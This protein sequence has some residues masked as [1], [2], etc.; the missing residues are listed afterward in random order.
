MFEV[1]SRKVVVGFF[2]SF[3]KVHGH[4]HFVLT[5]RRAGAAQASLPL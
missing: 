4:V 3:L 5:A 2:L 1:A